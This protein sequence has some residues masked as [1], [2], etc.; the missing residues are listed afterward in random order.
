MTVYISPEDKKLFEKNGFTTQKITEYVTY[1]REQGLSDD[2]IQSKINASLNFWKQSSQL[3]TTSSKQIKEIQTSKNE[4]K[5]NNIDIIVICLTT[6]FILL[7]I[8]AYIFQIY[9]TKLNKCV[10]MKI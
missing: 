4:N 7:T 1:Y 5:I 3:T 2:E 8:F 6:I 9:L 10:K